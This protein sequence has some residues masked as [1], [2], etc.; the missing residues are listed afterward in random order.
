MKIE[1]QYIVKNLNLNLTTSFLNAI[2]SRGRNLGGGV[3]SV[4]V[5]C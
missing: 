1:A 2:Q 3:G 4:S 5:K